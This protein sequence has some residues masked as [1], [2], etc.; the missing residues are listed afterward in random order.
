MNRKMILRNK[1]ISIYMS[2]SNN[3]TNYLMRSTQIRD[4]FAAVGWKVLDAKLVN[5]ALN[6]FTMSREPFVKGICAREHIPD[7]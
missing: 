5:V 7:W 2:R 6:R 3:V 1:L 4:Q